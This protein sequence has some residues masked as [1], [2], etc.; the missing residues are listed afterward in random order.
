[1]A[2]QTWLDKIRK[3]PSRG[4]SAKRCSENMQESYR[5]TPMQKCD[6]NKIALQS[7][8]HMGVVL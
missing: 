7:H 1:M 4:V 3:Q 2:Y 5:K 6:F 8:F